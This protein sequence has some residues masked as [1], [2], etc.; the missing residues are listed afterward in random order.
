MENI[1]LMPHQ[2]RVMEAM[3]TQRG[4]LVHHAMGSGKTITA[5]ATSVIMF[6]AG[7]VSNVHI[8]VPKT[9]VAYWQ[10]NLANLGLLSLGVFT[11]GT[12][13]KW[14]RDFSTGKTTL[15]PKS[16]VV[17]DEV[18]N[19]RSKIQ[20]KD[21]SMSKSFVTVCSMAHRVLLLTGTAVVNGVHDLRNIAVALAGLNGK[22]SLYHDEPPN[23]PKLQEQVHEFT[24]DEDYSKWY[25]KIELNEAHTL[26]KDDVDV[27]A[28]KNMQVFSNGIRRAVNGTTAKGAPKS[29]KLAWMEEN[30]PKWVGVGEK[31]VI[32]SAWLSFGAELIKV[33][34]DAANIKM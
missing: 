21:T 8:L 24:M 15:Q 10:Q 5:L 17:V 18:H 26:F 34:L 12:H 20:A 7:I 2:A 31:T 30:I 1:T 9:M 6:N 28:V 32:Y 29:P 19:M 23:A 14:L 13:H 33:A 27:R 4:L 25:D 22:V 3:M 16:L 11:I